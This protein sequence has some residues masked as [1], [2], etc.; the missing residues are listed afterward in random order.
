[1]NNKLGILTLHSGYNEGALLQAFCLAAN[2]RSSLPNSG[3]EIVDHR[4]PSKVRVYGPVRNERTR[5]LNDFFDHSLPLSGKRFLADDHR[6]T[7]EFIK[8]NYKAVVTGSDELWKLDYTKRFFGFVSEQNNPWCPAFPNVYWPDESVKIPKIAYAASIGHTDWQTIPR[9]HVRRMKHILSQ[10]TL[11]GIR[12]QRTMSFLK[13]LDTGMARKAEWVPDPT[14]SADILPLLDRETLKQK[15]QTLGVDFNRP[16][17]C[18]ILE[19]STNINNEV[20][21]GMKQRG[22]QIVALSLKNRFADVELFDKGFTPI[23]WA[24]I[25]GLMDFCVSQRMHACIYS[26]LNNIPF[27]AVD[28]Y[29]NPMDDETKVKDLMRSFNLLDYYYN[30]EKDPPEKFRVI[31]ENMIKKPWPV[32]EIAQKR[33][34]FNSRSREFTDKIKG[35]INDAVR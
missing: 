4:Y 33:L 22:F 18:I 15:L 30:A 6:P 27:V 1:M 26:I 8:E 29:S 7:F 21:E 31:C 35:V 23:E 13:W 9:K 2:L 3:V 34:L 16:R 11:L 12:D 14:F 17:I 5:A 19:G 10:Y 24:G 20:I 28:I 25:F 32:N